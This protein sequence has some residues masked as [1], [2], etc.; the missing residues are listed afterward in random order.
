MSVI[1]AHPAIPARRVMAAVLATGLVAFGLVI[2]SAPAA[3]A[4]TQVTQG[5]I[6]YELD[7]AAPQN[8]A[9]VV[10]NTG[11]PVGAVVIPDTITDSGV[12]YDVTSV[13][14]GAFQSAGVTSLVLGA[15]VTSIDDSA[16]DG[17]PFTSVEL[18]G[19][20]P[21]V[22]AD[23][24]GS[25]ATV[26]VYYPWR[27]GISQG[28]GYT[29]PWHGYPTAAVATVSFDANGHGTAPASASVI[30]GETTTAPTPSPSAPGYT[31]RRWVT[32]AAAGTRWEF[33]TGS[34][35]GDMTLYAGWQQNM[36]APVFI[37][38]ATSTATVG[39]SF[40]WTPDVLT[41]Y[42]DPTVVLMDNT[43]PVGLTLNTVTGVISGI[44]VDTAGDYTM[45][46]FADNG[47]GAGPPLT[48]TITLLPG[49]AQTVQ[50][51]P[52][53]TTVDQGGTVTITVTGVDQGGNSVDATADTAF[54][55]DVPTDVVDGNTV[56]FPH[57]SPHT[58]TATYTPTGMSASILITVIPAPS[59]PLAFTGT[60]TAQPILWT[61]AAILMA[62]ALAL[63]L[64]RRRRT[65][66]T[67]D[68][69]HPPR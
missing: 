67:D 45:N 22:G 1:F 19:A 40:T 20:E 51:Q 53:R 11:S 37:G 41:G 52:D 8:G 29:N 64:A 6:V 59:G 23:V 43:L 31:F 63:L 5:N 35:A 46:M 61:G 49:D 44:P 47:V 54:S 32:D 24:F 62:G 7:T 4:V 28:G 33:S 58:I 2:G 69:V 18:L 34:V 56:T 60:D 12:D 38:P 68:G 66:N 27:H 15:N 3:H 48:L 16:F 65:D 17:N 21:A 9:V 30:V 14:N 42:P 50:L 13:G 55:S 10:G 26:T 57:A 36:T 39:K 25:T